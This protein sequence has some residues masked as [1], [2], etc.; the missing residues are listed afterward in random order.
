MELDDT[1]C[2][3]FHVS[4]RKVVNYLRREQPQRVSQISTCLSAGTG[5]GWC[6]RMLEKLHGQLVECG[7]VDETDTVDTLAY[8]QQ[9]TA[10]L[11]ARKNKGR[12]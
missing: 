3:C 4:K 8:K 12:S 2:F 7:Q 6:I 5:C 1:L 11:Q 9:R 10:Y